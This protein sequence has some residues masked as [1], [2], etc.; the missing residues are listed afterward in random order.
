MKKIATGMRG[1]NVAFTVAGAGLTWQDEK[2]R[3]LAEVRKEHTR[4]SAEQ[5]EA[6]ADK[7][8][9]AQTIGNVGSTAIAS[10]TAGAAIGSAVPVAGTVIGFGVGLAV[11]WAMN[12]QG[13]EDADGDGEKDSIAERAGDAVEA[14]FKDPGKVAADVGNG[15]KKVAGAVAGW[16]GR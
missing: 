12:H 9:T 10:A 6:E 1:A 4:L 11:G 14:V 2:N 16:F 3:E 13:M 7:R 5:A 15:A 8:A